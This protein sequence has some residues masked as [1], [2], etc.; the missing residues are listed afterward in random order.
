MI[1]KFNDDTYYL[2]NFSPYPVKYNG[3]AYKNAEAAFQAQKCIKPD[4]RLLFA[5]LDS[6]QAKKL[7]R[8]I[9]LRPDWEFCKVNIMREIVQ[10]K[11]NQ[12]ADLR[13]RLL[14]TGD[15]YLEEGNDWGDR[16]WGTVDGKGANLLGLILMELRTQFRCK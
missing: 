15:E 11:F 10:A 8:K 16:I 6:S 1:N 3:V 9:S 5:D 13:E 2:S 4:D 7:G 14:S 12:N